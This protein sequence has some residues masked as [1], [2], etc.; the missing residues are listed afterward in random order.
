MIKMNMNNSFNCSLETGCFY[1]EE[2]NSRETFQLTELT[3]S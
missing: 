3:E 2:N 1:P